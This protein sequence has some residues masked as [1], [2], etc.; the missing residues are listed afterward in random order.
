AGLDLVLGEVVPVTNSRRN[1]LLAED[2]FR[3]TTTRYNFAFAGENGRVY[4]VGTL[5]TLQNRLDE[6]QVERR[7]TG[8]EYPTMLV[9][10]Q[11][12]TYE[13]AGWSLNKGEMKLVTDSNPEFA[14]DFSRM[15]D[16]GF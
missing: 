13:R 15:R 16:K 14:I 10:A 4:K 3:G 1:D 9:S 11:Y 7:G 2:K 8:A 12:A 6:L 5:N